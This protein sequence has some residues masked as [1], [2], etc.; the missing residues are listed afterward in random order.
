ML[1]QTHS[2]PLTPPLK[3]QWLAKIA[4]HLARKQLQKKPH[5]VFQIRLPDNSIYLERHTVF[6]TKFCTLY[7]HRFVQS[8]D[9]ATFHTHPWPSIS[10][11]L[12]GE[13]HELVPQ[14]LNNPLPARYKTIRHKQGSI[15]IR[16]RSCL[17]RIALPQ[18]SEYAET[19]ILTGPN[20]QTWFFCSPTGKMFPWR[21]WLKIPEKI[22]NDG[23]P[24]HKK[25]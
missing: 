25:S 22:S 8:D 15:V 9:D 7:Y 16:K 2:Y 14:D 21:R 19:L 5:P 1:K 20:T 23:R 4:K 6:K 11:S 12:T 10:L 13:T 17:H 3:A 18:N 24:A